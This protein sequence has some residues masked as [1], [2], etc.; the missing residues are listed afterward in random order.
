MT[1][2]CRLLVGGSSQPAV[3]CDSRIAL[4]SALAIVL[5]ALN[6]IEYLPHYIVPCDT[7]A[8]AQDLQMLLCLNREIRHALNDSSLRHDPLA[9]RSCGALAE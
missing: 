3:A 2:P 7:L 9:A 4:N 5:D 8:G 6:T 1:S